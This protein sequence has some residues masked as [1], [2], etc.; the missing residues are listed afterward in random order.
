MKQYKSEIYIQLFRLVMDLGCKA[1]QLLSAIVLFSFYRWIWNQY[2]VIQTLISSKL[3]FKK[4]YAF[5]FHVVLDFFFCNFKI[6][7]YYLFSV[8]FS[9]IYIQLI[10]VIQTN[11]SRCSWFALVNLMILLWNFHNLLWLILWFFL[12]LLGK[13]KHGKVAANK[14][15][16]SWSQ[17]GVPSVF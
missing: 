4:L 5:C 2:F 15:L 10:S 13:L 6:Q 12:C 16:S 9:E 8:I 14:V 17:Q 7:L 1:V 11:Y 3:W